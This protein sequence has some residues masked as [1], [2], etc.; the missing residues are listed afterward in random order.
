MESSLNEKRK[1]VREASGVRLGVS[2]RHI[3]FEMAVRHPSQSTKQ[4]IRNTS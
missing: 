2:F 4:A 1:T 3:L